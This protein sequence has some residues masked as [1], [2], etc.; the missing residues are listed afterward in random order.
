M[1]RLVLILLATVVSAP[2]AYAA[3]LSAAYPVKAAPVVPVGPNWAG[4][5]G[6]LNIGYGFNAGGHSTGG[7]TYYENT[8]HDSFDTEWY[9]NEGPSWRTSA[10]LDGVIG[11]GQIGYNF[12]FQPSV[13]FGVETDF[14]WSGL[15]GD[16]SA[17]DTTSIQLFPA[18]DPNDPNYWAVEGNSKVTQEVEW[19]G[20][21][22]ARLGVTTFNDSLLIYGT[23]GLAY[24]S[25]RQKLNYTGGFLPDAQLGFAGSHWSGEA[26]S[27]ETKVGWTL[28][29]GVE[30][31]PAAASN[32]SIKAEYLYTDLGSTKVDLSTPAYRNDTNAG[33]RVVNASN[34]A[35]AQWQTVRVGINY[36]F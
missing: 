6:G 5:Y 29:G 30:W 22:R 4:F 28:G 20:T 3:D 19:F 1:K 24:G 18:F 31:F 16:A 10:N 33:G 36:H 23:G 14:Q 26:S 8:T 35:D 2:A 7:Q 12:V 13:L 34:T 17:S 15:K 32:W 21:V 25:V 27:S 9:T 11:G